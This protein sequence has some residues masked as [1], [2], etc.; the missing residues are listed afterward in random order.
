MLA[1]STVP[2]LSSEYNRP[3][4]RVICFRCAHP[5]CPLTPSPPHVSGGT[6][7]QE[8]SFPQPL[9]IPSHWLPTSSHVSGTQPSG[10]PPPLPPVPPPPPEG[11]C[12]QRPLAPHTI[13]GG[14]SPS[15]PWGLH[16]N[17]PSSKRSSTHAP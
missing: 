16:R 12:A 2:M 14:H 5:H 9:E 8:I 1:Q 10:F 7:S 17:C 6:Q 11:W 15:P 3:T 13:S 4:L